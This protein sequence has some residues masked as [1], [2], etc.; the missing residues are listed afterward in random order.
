M[1]LRIDYSKELRIGKIGVLLED[2]YEKAIKEKI[3][4]IKRYMPKILGI[5]LLSQILTSF[6]FD[7]IVT[8]YLMMKYAL[9]EFFSLGDFSASV[10]AIWKFFVQI[11]AITN[12]V[13][14][15]N[16]HSIYID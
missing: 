6:L 11:N 5:S 7:A 15:F 14:R 4:C 2:E 10:N 9:D 12:Y 13:S 1:L 8:G 3:D 16:E